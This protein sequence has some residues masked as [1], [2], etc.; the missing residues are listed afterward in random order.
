MNSPNIR[1]TN[2]DMLR[3]VVM[4]L[5]CIDH[6]RDYTLYHPTDPMILSDIPFSVILLRFLSHFCAPTFIFLAG[7]SIWMA[8]K[9]KDKTE[10]SFFLLTRGAILCL[11]EI[12]IVNWGWSFNPAF[13]TIYLQI[14]W[15]IGISMIAMS[16]L[17]YLPRHILACCCII[18]LLCHNS[19][20]NVQFEENSFMFYLWSFLIQK[21]LLP[22][23]EN[24]MVRTT[25]PVLP[26]MAI[27]GLGYIV[28]KWYTHFDSDKRK[29]YLLNTSLVMV[30]SFVFFRIII[31][32]GDSSPIDTNNGIQSYI[33]SVM[34][35]T[36]YPMSLDFILIYLSIPI[37]IL[38]LTDNKNFIGFTVTLGRVPMF[39]YVLHI[40]ILHLLILIWLIIHGEYIDLYKNLGGVPSDTGYP[41][42]ILL[43]IVPATIAI[44]YIPCK[45]Y[46][47]IKRKK[48]YTITN[49]L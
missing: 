31:G 47:N 48:Q 3:G 10:L 1:L 44:L 8:G 34:N 33:I 25:Y 7:I 20:S 37:C 19:F 4:I 32:Y 12:T 9:K 16:A 14:I 27:M 15:A 11:L 39:F 22:L 18:I 36:K 43:F 30:S 35:T 13:H 38:S 41:I 26:V 17:L 29:K 46:Y 40:Y 42:E 23:G 24:I 49:Y 2:I 6:A 45:W 28:G 21:N 5:M